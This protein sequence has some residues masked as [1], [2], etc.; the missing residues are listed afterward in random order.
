MTDTNTVDATREARTAALEAKLKPFIVQVRNELAS[1]GPRASKAD[2]ATILI[3][4]CLEAGY[5]TEYWI[6]RIARVLP[7]RASDVLST[8]NEKSGPD[9]LWDCDE[10]ERYSL[11]VT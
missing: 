2:L 6:E 5:R 11:P 9:G 7:L 10:N 4:E 1:H 3:L 8:L